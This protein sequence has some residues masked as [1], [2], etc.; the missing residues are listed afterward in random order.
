MK[1]R[2]LSFAFAFS[3]VALV[4]AQTGY[5]Q[6]QK[7]TITKTDKFDFGVG[8]TVSIVGAPIGSITVTGNPKNEIEITAQIQIEAASEQ[9]LNI[10]A[11]VT[12]FVLQEATGR[13]SILSSGTN[14]KLGDKKTWKK[15]PKALLGLPFR[16]DYVIKVPRYCDL[17]INGGKGD[18][19]IS[20][21]EGTFKVAATES[22][23]K[24]DL[25]GGGIA[26]TL[27]SGTVDITMPDRSW[28]GNTIDVALA[29]GTLTAHLPSSISADLDAA[30]LK[31][32]KIENAFVDW[33]PRT[34][35]VPFTEQSV[36]AKAGN[37]GVPMKFTVGE[38][39]LRLM[40]IAKPN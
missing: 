40:R 29:S 28:R 27:G 26:A 38:G 11:Q 31:S 32:G 10:L 21:I 33:K 25:I 18:I 39:T 13:V 24:F 7:R 23:A 19:D 34:R 22:N 4:L 6:N 5:A 16:I 37:G 8:G 35:T 2:N 36:I 14:N 15:F 30:I 9:N 17:E 12:T 1:N 3:V 20:G